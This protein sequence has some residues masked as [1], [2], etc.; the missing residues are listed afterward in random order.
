MKFI[1]FVQASMAGKT[2]MLIEIS[3]SRPLILIP[4]KD[5]NLAFTTLR[6]LVKGQAGIPVFNYKSMLSR[7]RTIFLYVRLF[8]LAYLRFWK[9]Y[10]YT[11]HSSWSYTTLHQRKIFAALMLNGGGEVMSILFKHYVDLFMVRGQDYSIEEVMFII[12]LT[13]LISH[14]NT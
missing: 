5:E 8:Y 7:A 2:R 13:Y 6:G 14:I 3:L 10:F 11:I 4:F 1:G 9:Y 12:E